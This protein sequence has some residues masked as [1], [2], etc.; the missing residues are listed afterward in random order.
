MAVTFRS[1][2]VS[3]GADSTT[4]V[5]VKPA[6]LS[7]D[8]LMV[9]QVVTYVYG[10]AVT[11][12][13]SWTEIRQ[14]FDGTVRDIRSALF[15]KIAVQ[16]DVDATDFTFTVGDEVNLG[17][18]TAWT[19]HDSVT[20]INADNGQVNASSTTI[21]SPGI[22]PSVADCEILLF[23]G[24][25]T[26]V[27]TTT[28]YALATDNPGTW[29]E[30]YDQGTTAGRDI[31]QAMASATRPETSAT[32]NGTA[33]VND[34]RKNIGQ[35]VAI[36]PVQSIAHEKVLSDT[37]S[38]ADSIEK[39]VGMFKADSVA[40]AESPALVAEFKRSFGDTM[41]IADVISKEPGLVKSDSLAITEV[42]SKQPGINI[43]DSISIAESLI[44]A[45]GL[46]KADTV[47]IVE[48][49]EKAVGMAL[50]DTITISDSVT[51]V[52][53]FFLAISDTIAI[54]ES[55][56]KESG[57]NKDDAVAIADT[58]NTKAIGLS[59]ADSITIAETI[60][61][62][63]S[64]PQADSINIT[65]SISKKPGL[66][67]ADSISISDIFS[68]VMVYLRSLS[69][70]ILMTDSISKAISIIK[71]DTMTIADSIGKSLSITFSDIISIADQ[72]KLIYPVRR[73]VTI[74]RMTIKRIEQARLPH[75]K[76]KE[77]DV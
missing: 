49:V 23:A 1:V 61:K 27:V 54:A 39:D 15:W 34:S 52:S 63:V 17:A 70:T 66:V 60:I 68:R 67:L 45:I 64:I 31:S 20:P 59:K 11:P 74:A 56:S 73:A 48:A 22:T 7:V 72:A 5:I 28:G 12:P 16:A 25:A 76:L 3:P 9:A 43:A 44:K 53:E 57:L 42:I 21:T 75:K 13:G 6:G 77:E 36:A 29:N 4:C 71:A 18:I 65:D 58:L 51:D 41:G 32:G 46:V 55:I 33:T 37:I 50:S 10:T 14:D 40:I 8:D 30:R 69:D 19:G 24:A 47:N 62:A 38:I 26:L 35:L 2:G